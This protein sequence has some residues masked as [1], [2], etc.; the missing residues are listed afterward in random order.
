MTSA[1]AVDAD[2]QVEIDRLRRTYASGRTRAR[3]WR[4]EQL[5]GMVRLLDEQEAR[6]AQA[7]AEDLG[8]SAHEAWLGDVAST[9]AEAS[10]ARRRLRSWMRRRSTGL[11]LSMMPGRAFYQYEP[12]GT[13]L[14][15][16]PWNYPVYLSLGP[17]VA[18]IAAGN[19]VVLKPSEHAPA[20]AA[21]LAELLPRYCDP[22]A[23][24]VIEG[25]AATTQGLVAAGVDH[26]FFTGGPEIATHVAR[27]AAETLTP[28]T[29]ELGGKSPAIVTAEADLDVTAR[30]L[31][32][33]KLLNAGQTC[34]APDY[35]LVDETVQ[36]EL[37]DRLVA[38]VVEFR[39][40]QPA[41]QRVVNTRHR[42]RLERLLRG[43][44]GRVVVGGGSVVEPP[45]LE[46][47]VVVGPDPSSALMQEEIFGPILPVVPTRSLDDAI[48][49]VADRPK[50]LGLYLFSGSARER[51]KVLAETSSG[52]VVVN[53]AAMH[54]LVP[55]LPFGG[56]G[57]SGTGSYHGVWGFQALSHRKAV[58]SKP[59]RPDPRFVYPPYTPRVE[60]LMRRLF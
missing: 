14:V 23:V 43:H 39:A 35:V 18:A 28:V 30:R 29:L 5:D 3:A 37:V 56:V 9:R 6:I 48:A 27:A 55:H 32:W 46:P 41:E 58:L 60:R 25:D 10:H 22:D 1:T 17:I 11:P 7:L 44:G 47:T 38:A 53:H 54:C 31:A 4:E 42:E 13:V 33:V 12:L 52:G 49:F 40:G 51:E 15:I 59:G 24:S 50:P 21:L 57:H 20:S 34:I 26:V 8:R 45:A 19:T 36:Q 2:L 16:A